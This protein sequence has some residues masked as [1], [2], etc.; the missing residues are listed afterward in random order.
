MTFTLLIE[1]AEELH[2][3]CP[4]KAVTGSGS[5]AVP[6][7]SYADQMQAAV[8]LQLHGHTLHTPI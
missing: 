5:Y 2:L 4:F 8:D 1:N 7:G 6:G 3:E